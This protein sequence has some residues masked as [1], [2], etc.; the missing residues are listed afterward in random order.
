MT[1]TR[2]ILS[3]LAVAV[4]LVAALP[5]AAQQIDGVLR[6][7]ASTGDFILEIDGK[8]ATSAKVYRSDLPAIL[9]I[10]D[11]LPSP[12]LI[13][14]R[15]RSVQTVPFMKLVQRQDGMA[16]VLADAELTPVGGLTLEGESI[17]FTVAGQK[18]RLKSRPFLIGEQGLSDM[19]GHSPEYRRKAEA[20]TPDSGAL[21]ALKKSPK[22]VRVRVYFGSWC[23]FCSR[24][25]PNM[26]KVAEQLEGDVDFEFYG[27]PQG[28]ADE[29]AAKRDDVHGVPTGIVYVGGKEVGRLDAREWTNPE[30]AVQ[31][32]V[33]AAA[34][35][36]KG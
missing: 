25:V 2:T 29:P 15:E 33:A 10:A 24:Y 14:L 8:E 20:Y 32:L 5:A 3:A 1:R 17:R 21:A 16:D 28:F 4:A 6:D 7:F 22:P 31:R 12:T 11:E 30:G 26:L 9:L 35:P 36:A 27:L 13:L 34:A 23:P 19:L 18:M